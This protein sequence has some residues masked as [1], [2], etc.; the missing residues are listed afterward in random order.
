MNTQISTLAPRSIRLLLLAGALALVACVGA[1]AA[2]QGPPRGLTPELLAQL[3]AGTL[4][5]MCRHGITNHD[6]DPLDAGRRP[7]DARPLNAH[8]ERQMRAV[9]AAM[10][11]LG[12]PSCEVLASPYQRTRRSAQ[13]LFGRVV[14]EDALFGNGK[15]ARLHALLGTPPERAENRILMTHQGVIY[16][17]FPQ[18]PRQ[19]VAEGDC[20]IVRPEGGSRFTL[21]GQVSADDWSAAANAAGR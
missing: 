19:S 6:P 18:L 13:L 5:L 9:G 3:R 11:L 17:T 15:E 12:I 20:L 2:A 21:L 16:R 14:V 1:P 10:D 7:H 4:V 8:G